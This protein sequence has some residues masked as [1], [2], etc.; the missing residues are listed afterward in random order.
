[1]H[2]DNLILQNADGST[3]TVGRL[4]L[5]D[6]QGR[7]E[8]W[9]RDLLFSNPGAI[10]ISDLDPSFGP[11]VP[12][13]C[14]LRTEAGP[15]D[16]AY[17]NKDG[18]LTLVECKLWR[19]PEARRKVVAQVLDYARAVAEW[20][21][22]DLQRQVSAALGKAGNVPYALVKAT[23]PDL[24]EHR[25]VDAT[26]RSMGRGRFQLIVAGDGIRED[27]SAI[28]DL[29]NRNASSA[30]AFSMIEIALYSFGNTL[31]IQ[32]RV[33]AKTVTVERTVV[34]V[35]DGQ[36]TLTTR[37]ADAPEAAEEQHS[38]ERDKRKAWWAPLQ[39]TTFDDPDQEPAKW[40]WPNNLYTPLPIPGL[41][42][43]AYRSQKS[44]RC[45]VFFRGRS[46]I[47]R[48]F[49]PMLI[50]GGVL[51]DLPSGTI[52]DSENSGLII[53]RREADFENVEAEHR[54]LRETMNVFVNA[55]RPRLKKLRAID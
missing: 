16:I 52:R 39:G 6:T 43:S 13:C 21:Y 15:I 3:Q 35:Q 41:W 2:A 38:A 20:G 30:F 49:E 12:L 55:L 7:D 17:I 40:S 51:A 19:N 29:V 34:V 4:A 26:S 23:A 14:E 22:A 42:I 9:L 54:W 46:A 18:L 24:E 11:L 27:V 53:E 45:G 48:Q 31:A 36:E 8:R 28:A 25:F 50:E 32:P 44:G 5:G 33:I 1:M 37:S 47:V 10:P